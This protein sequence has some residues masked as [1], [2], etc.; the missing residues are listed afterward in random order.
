[1]LNLNNL[2]HFKR[3]LLFLKWYVH[4]QI[5]AN[6]IFYTLSGISMYILCSSAVVEDSH[7]GD[8][9]LPLM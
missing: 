1:M 6:C 5:I 2:E 8:P 3:Q 7:A 4:K 9:D